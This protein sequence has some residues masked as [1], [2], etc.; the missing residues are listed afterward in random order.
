MVGAGDAPSVVEAGGWNI[1]IPS[2]FELSA[3]SSVAAAV[4]TVVN[5][6]LFSGAPPR[7][8][9]EC[10]PGAYLRGAATKSH[11]VAC[12]PPAGHG[13]GG[14]RSGAGGLATGAG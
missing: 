11:T 10:T 6:D 2:P 8:G 9:G 1:S 7:S 12:D 4:G 13:S 14:G 3:D 5:L